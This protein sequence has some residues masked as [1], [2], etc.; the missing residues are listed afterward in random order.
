[1]N[2]T[3]IIIGGG[4]A[5]VNAIKAIRELDQTSDIHLIQNENYYP[6]Y[7]IRL[8]KGMFD[9]IDIDRLMLQK[10][11][12]Y[13]Q[14]NVQ[15]YLGR[16]AIAIDTENRKV[17]LDDGTELEFDTLLLANGASNATPRIE[18]IE[19]GNVFSIRKLKDIET[20]RANV[21]NKNVVL[22]IGGGV[23]N[24]EAAWAMCT[25]GK[26]VTIAEF[27]DRLMPRQLDT[28]ASDLLK[29]AVLNSNMQILLNTE[30]T[31]ITGTDEA[32]GAA[33]KD[34]KRIE[35][36]MV[37]YS[38]GVRPNIRLFENT[39]LQ[40]NRGI[41]VD[42]QMQTNLD[43]IYAAGDVAEI[44]GK[45]GGLWS[46]AM[47]QGK[48]AGKNISGKD[49]IYSDVIPV[50]NMNAFNLSVFSI[51]NIDEASVS[52]TITEE[53]TDESSY[54]RIFIQDNIIVGAIIL[55]DTKN[56][57]LLKKFIENK[58]L[59]SNIDF[60]TITVNDLITQLRSY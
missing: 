38:V 57:T 5:A 32:N 21:I 16:E 18:G 6:Y 39:A 52:H 27:Q 60:N 37:I 33:T 23:Q 22:C 49:A 40:I 42:S 10:R 15:V 56:N 45:V 11:E 59:L 51:G 48:I 47:E 46:I 8:T 24:L 1:M 55:G 44:N 36:D 54:R 4:V 30:I 31:K 26:K 35:C 25:Q 53:A 20:I 19:K 9:T 29:K 34:G 43:H 13:E 14:N 7:R 28:K 12:W 2:N 3:I 41:V 58:T 50:T 17:S